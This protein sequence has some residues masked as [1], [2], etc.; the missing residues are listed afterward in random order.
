VKQNTPPFLN[1]PSSRYFSLLSG[2]LVQ[3]LVGLLDLQKNHSSPF[4]QELIAFITDHMT[5]ISM[6]LAAT[7]FG[8]HKNYFPTIVKKRTNHTFL[9][10][11]TDIRLQRAC[12]LLL[13][14]ADSIEEISASIGYRSTASFYS[15]FYAR[16]KMTPK[17]YRK[18]H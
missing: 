2:C 12:N 4:V 5:D 9:E 7:H 17:E 8:Y 11:V 15:K 3:F 13:L 16:F 10:L 18:R 6:E 14:T 1:Q